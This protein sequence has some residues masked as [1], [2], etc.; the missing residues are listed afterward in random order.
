MHNIFTVLKLQM[1]GLNCCDTVQD[2]SLGWLCETSKTVSA[3]ELRSKEICLSY[4]IELVKQN[5]LVYMCE[6]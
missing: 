6:T 4:G 5:I 3:E 1:G 2:V